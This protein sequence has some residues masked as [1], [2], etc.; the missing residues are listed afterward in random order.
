MPAPDARQHP[1]PHPCDHCPHHRPQREPERR[2]EP[3]GDQLGYR[4]M[5]FD[6][7]PQL[8]M[9]HLVEVA[10]I[11]LPDRPVQPQLGARALHLLQR[12]L[13]PGHHPR[14]V[15]GQQMHEREHKHADGQQDRN[16]ARQPPDDIV[17]H[18]LR[19]SFSSASRPRQAG[20]ADHPASRR[21]SAASNTPPDYATCRDTAAPHPPTP[22]SA[23][24][25]TPP[26]ACPG[27]P[28]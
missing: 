24:S 15:P 26:P 20:T 19:A 23:Q 27:R 16:G 12:R 11:L 5:R 1:Q 10:H 28:C 18:P 21:P 17:E 3:L 13:G 22:P 2:H 14:G 9:R 4:F 8:E 6:R 25:H 7:A